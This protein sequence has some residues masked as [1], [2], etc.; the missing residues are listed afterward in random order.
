[1]SYDLGQVNAPRLSGAALQ[2]YTRNALAD[3]G[4]LRTDLRPHSRW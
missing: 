4:V 1:M 3:P 2:G